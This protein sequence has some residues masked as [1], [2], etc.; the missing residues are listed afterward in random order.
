MKS[1]LKIFTRYVSSAAGIA[2]VLVIVNFMLVFFWLVRTRNDSPVRLNLAEISESIIRTNQGFQISSDGEK[3]FKDMYVWGMLLDDSGKV[4]WSKNIP[5]D[6][7]SSFTVKEVASFSRWYYRNYPT[8]VWDHPDGLLVVGRPPN[9]TWKHAIEM[10]V[11]TMGYMPIWIGMVF[12]INAFVALFL[13]LVLGWRMFKSINPLLDGI[14]KL[15]TLQPLSLKTGGLL[16][17]LA[18]KLNQTSKQLIQQE[19]ALKKRDTARTNWISG[20]SHDIRTPLSMV[21]GYASQL[22]ENTSLSEENQNKA[23]IIRR[24][25]EKIKKL[26]NDLNLASKLEYD[27]Q[28]LRMTK[29]QPAEL[30]RQ[31][32]ADKLNNGLPAIFSIQLD[33]TEKAQTENISGDEAL[34][35]RAVLNLLD[36]CVQHNPDGCSIDIQ[37]DVDRSSY[38]IIVTDDGKGCQDKQ[39]SVSEESENVDYYP[40]KGLGLTIVHQIM[41]SHRGTFILKS[42]QNQGCSAILQF[43]KQES[44]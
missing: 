19:E 31:V 14:K 33:I 1:G 32:V 36:N 37:L 3:A 21:M 16:G 18:D 8:Y 44:E 39:L 17:D 25:S 34:I 7:P 43:P 38:T 20:I 12:L 9:S 28:P 24:Q 6:F 29:V 35:Q 23:G 15:S 27:M 41:K 5:Q 4:I 26:V 10:P 2:L 42:Q 40:E 11:D 13:A 22:E 30:V